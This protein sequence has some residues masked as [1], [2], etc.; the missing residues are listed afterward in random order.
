MLAL[1]TSTTAINKAGN[2]GEN[3]ASE[4][5]PSKLH[6]F[7][8]KAANEL[9]KYE[10]A[11]NHLPFFSCPK[12]HFPNHWEYWVPLSHLYY[13]ALTALTFDGHFLE[14]HSLETFV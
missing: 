4:L 8:C 10:G 11:H 7:F 13:L 14:V 6:P 1:A 5:Y 9:V 2:Y 3:T 12:L